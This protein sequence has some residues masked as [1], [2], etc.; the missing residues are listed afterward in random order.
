MERESYT[1][2]GIDARTIEENMKH[3]KGFRDWFTIDTLPKKMRKN[4]N[5]IVNLDILTGDG[6]HW[7]C[8]YNDPKY[9]FVE[10]FDPFGEYMSDD[11]E[12]P[13]EIE[14]YL[15][16]SNKHIRYSSNFQQK[17]SSVKCGYYYMKYIT[18]RN[19]GKSPARVVYS[20]TQEPS[21]YNENFVSYK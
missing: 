20:F 9:E 3:R 8:Y 7:V 16:T 2:L 1:K 4:E 6:T 14:K 11:Y 18:K 12:L 15:K 13:D 5:G 10:Y 19:K 17:P 21:N